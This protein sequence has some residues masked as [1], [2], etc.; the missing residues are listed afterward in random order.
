MR[1]LYFG[2]CEVINT[3]CNWDNPPNTYHDVL[4]HLSTMP[5]WIELVKR[6]ACRAGAMRTLALVK[7]YHPNVD[8]AP[9]VKG[10]PQFNVD[11]SQFDKKSYA[12]AVK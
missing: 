12:H 2:S 11:G 7:A 4:G 8:P 1:Q 5:Q 3:V 10:F 9:L 6:S